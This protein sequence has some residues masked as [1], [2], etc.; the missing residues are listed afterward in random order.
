VIDF[1]GVEKRY[2]GAA[3]A[4][5]AA[6]RF[7]VRTGELLV[8]LGESGSGKTTLLK[9]VNRLLEP[10]AGVVR[11]G[12]EDVRRLDPVTLRRGIGWVI[13]EVGLF[14]HMS[15]AD[16]VAVVPRLLGWARA[17]IDARVVELLELVGLPA[18]AFA[19][20]FPAELS[21]G[22]RQRVG[23]ARA[24]A[25][26]P[27]LLL[28]DEPL[29][30]LDPIT[31]TSLQGELRRLHDRLGLTTVLVTHDLHEALRLADRV[32]V[33]RRGELRQLGTPAELLA[34]PADAY[35]A[36]LM[37]SARRQAEQIV[38]LAAGAQAAR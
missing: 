7:S 16:N 17:E 2:P 13:Q 27:R 4:A 38:A 1:E 29:G 12:G 23:L 11:V 10:S 28:M 14:P 19:A 36:E 34:A 8:L 21:G 35:V 9:L 37:G 15:V 18:S 22:Q 6:T 32:A 33:L 24:L 26:R 31:R 20:R 30:A 3:V 25:A 5:L